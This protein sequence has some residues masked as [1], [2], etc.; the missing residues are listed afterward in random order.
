MRISKENGAANIAYYAQGTS[1]ISIAEFQSGTVQFGYRKKNESTGQMALYNGFEFIGE[2]ITKFIDGRK[3]PLEFDFSSNK[4]LLGDC[5]DG[6]GAEYMTMITPKKD[7]LEYFY[8]GNYKGG[9][10]DGE[11]AYFEANG[12]DYFVGKFLNNKEW[13][14]GY[15][16]HAQGMSMFLVD[17][18]EVK[19]MSYSIPEFKGPASQQQTAASTQPKKGGFWRSFGE[20]AGEVLI[21]AMDAGS[22]PPPKPSSTVAASSKG[23]AHRVEMFIS[24][25]TY[26][27]ID[28][29]YVK[30]AS[31]VNWGEDILGD[32]YMVHENGD[33]HIFETNNTDCVY[34]IKAKYE[35]GAIAYWYNLNVCNYSQFELKVNGSYGQKR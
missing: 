33:W 6:L 18:K 12:A 20:A 8:V 16:N 24:N 1:T 5:T 25:K 32:N 34:N 28:E 4:C 35:N 26:K 21:G 15:F 14:G 11:G 29:L 23:G 10:W 7:T 27:Q 13:N 19:V 2:Q 9:K 22:K 30:A 31:E 3:Y 17:G